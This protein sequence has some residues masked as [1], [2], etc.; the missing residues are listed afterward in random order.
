MHAGG[1]LC[2]QGVKAKLLSTTPGA[3][4]TLLL[5]LLAASASRVHP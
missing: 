5:S 2:T 4:L 1:L 3:T